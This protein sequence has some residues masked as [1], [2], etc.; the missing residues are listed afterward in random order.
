ML[1]LFEKHLSKEGGKVDKLGRYKIS[2][3]PHNV[4]SIHISY[5]EKKFHGQ[6]LSAK[7]IAAEV[8]SAEELPCR[9]VMQ[10]ID[11]TECM[12]VC[13]YWHTNCHL[14]RQHSNSIKPRLHT[15]SYSKGHSTI[16]LYI[17]RA[18]FDFSRRELNT[19]DLFNP[20]EPTEFCDTPCAHR[21]RELEHPPVLHH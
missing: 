12:Q 3:N 19:D 16:F 9:Y 7:R 6:H 18:R 17:T 1:P 20:S 5:H 2:R 13:I 4:N 11:L 21:I 8:L 14:R 10:A 15:D